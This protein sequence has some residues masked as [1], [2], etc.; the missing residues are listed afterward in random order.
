[1]SL[2]NTQYINNT[3]IMESL[4]SRY[5]NSIL[6]ILSLITEVSYIIQYPPHTTHNQACTLQILNVAKK[7][8][9]I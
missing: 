3:D 7:Y 6:K 5:T 8:C 9:L 1:M 4:L 2:K